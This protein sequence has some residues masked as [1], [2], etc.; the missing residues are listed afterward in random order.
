MSEYIRIIG[1]LIMFVISLYIGERVGNAV[2]KS[3]GTKAI[4][5][6]VG[7]LIF[8]IVFTGGSVFLG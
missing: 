8:L 4:G 1:P 5:W 7:I 3:T 2:T 6:P